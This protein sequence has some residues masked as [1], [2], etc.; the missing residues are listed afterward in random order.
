MAN[1]TTTIDIS[2]NCASFNKELLELVNTTRSNIDLVTKSFEVLSNSFPSLSSTLRGVLPAIMAVTTA[3]ESWSVIKKGQDLIQGMASYWRT[4][5]GAV[6]EYNIA[7]S[8][9][10]TAQVANTASLTLGQIAVGLITGKITLATAATMAWN[11]VLSSNVIGIVIT[12]LAG[13]GAG[14]FAYKS[15][16]DDTT[17]G[18]ES[19]NGTVDNLGT[20]YEDVGSKVSEFYNGISSA[21]SILDDFNTSMIVSSDA[22]AKLK[23]DLEKVQSDITTITSNAAEERRKL[24]DEEI[25]RLDGLFSK[26]NELSQKEMDN[27]T[28]YQQVVSD[29]AKVLADTHSGSLEEYEDYSQRL[30]KSAEETKTALIEKADEQCNEQ[31]YLINQKYASVEERESEAYKQEILNA[32]DKYTTSVEMATKECSD[33]LGI[34]QK[35]YVDRATELQSY[36]EAMNGLK[37]EE[38]E[39]EKAYNIAKEEEEK[40][41]GEVKW[42]SRSKDLEEIS[43]FNSNMEGMNK[44]HSDKMASIKD[45]ELSLLDENVSKQASILLGMASET[46]LNGGKVSD[47]MKIMCNNILDNFDRL[48]EETKK[49]MENVLKP[50]IE[51]MQREEPKL[52]NQATSIADGILSRLK[53]SFDIHSPSRKT[54]KIFENVMLGAEKG[55]EDREP[56]LYKKVE[57]VAGKVNDQFLNDVGGTA[58]RIRE[59][60]SREALK[61][62]ASTFSSSGYRANLEGASN[63]NNDNGIVQNVTINQP[64]K[65]PYETARVLRRVGRDLAF[66]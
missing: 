30:I 66:G 3:I 6:N 2:L 31:I 24:T 53:K 17:S 46:E 41:F 51:Q 4:A 58:S 44:E 37:S 42:G 8:V 40:R 38:L 12:A 59:N 1:Q 18:M 35:G 32:Q 55:L 56:I 15:I 23:E 14:M 39:T 10:T 57:Y 64:V 43:L 29:R 16:Q 34:I 5:V 21:K 25:G 49:D 27:M 61:I 28:Q 65:S 62:S 22:E 54:R 33:T 48:P 60:I 11:A 45:R 47:E 36:N 50:M 52:F 26:M 19:L 13:L 7:N 20:S 63:I 9:A